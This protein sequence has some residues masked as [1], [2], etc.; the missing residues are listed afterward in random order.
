[1]TQEANSPYLQGKSIYDNLQLKAPLIPLQQSDI[2]ITGSKFSF[3]GIVYLNLDFEKPGSSVYTLAYEP[4]LV[5]PNVST[6]TFGIKTELHFKETCR[7]QKDRTLMFVT[8]DNDEIV[9]L[10]YKETD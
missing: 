2:S 10:F 7:K 6:S 1:M 4:V 3:D 5:S 8:A 9:M